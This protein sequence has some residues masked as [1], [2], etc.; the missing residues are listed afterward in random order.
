[1]HD[2][3]KQVPA[4]F[5]HRLVLIDGN[6][7]IHR[8]FFAVK[9]SLTTSSG[10][11]TNALLGFS[12]MLLNILEREKPDHMVVTFD[13]HAPTFRH[14]V[15]EEYKGTRTKAPDELYVQIPRIREMVAAFN[16]PIYTKAGYEADDVMG[17]LAVQAKKDHLVSFIVTGDM[18]M[19]QLVDDHIFVVFPHKGYREPTL[20]DAEQVYKKY[21]I[22]P[23]QVVDYKA[24]VGDGSD[25][26]KG[27]FGIGPK[28]AI[29][30]LQQ[31][32]TLDNVFEHLS[33]LP[34]SVRTKLE[35]GR[36]DAFFSR[37]LAK[38]VTDAPVIFDEP[39][40]RL[41]QFDFLALDRFFETME[42]R[43]L[44]RRLKEMD[45]YR[46]MATKNQLSLF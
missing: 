31:Y 10:E 35:K 36:D 34:D 44:S 46:S 5:T 33:E 8:A 6:H 3:T 24:L 18:D 22:R 26:I 39:S 43:S 23:D 19:L 42:M 13:E 20:F 25:N 17:T 16:I 40:A 45:G 1:M 27:V 41:S 14:E 37:S 29:Q 11:P 2:T 21:G 30:L 4:D 32:H 28:G 12:S 38:I 15:H 9:A 7:L